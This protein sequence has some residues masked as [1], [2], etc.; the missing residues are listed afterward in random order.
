MAMGHTAQ[1]AP[2]GL[3]PPVEPGHFGVQAGFIEENELGDGPAGL[4]ALPL[5]A[6]QCDVR[7]VLLCGAQGFFYS[8]NRDVLAGATG[9]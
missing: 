7:S 1:A 8:S 5:L 4:A 3:G 2:G 9:R 6:G